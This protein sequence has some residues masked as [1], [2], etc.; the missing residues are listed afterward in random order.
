M[1]KID[2]IISELTP[3]EEAVKKYKWT[4]LDKDKIKK[5][6]PL[7]IIDG[8][9][10]LQK[11]LFLKHNLK[12]SLEENFENHQK[13]EEFLKSA[14]WVIQDWGKI[15]LKRIKNNND[16]TNDNIVNNFSKKIYKG[17]LDLDDREA[18]IIS[19]L[20]KVASFLKP[21]RCAIYDSRAVLSL[22]WLLFKYNKFFCKKELYFPQPKGAG[23]ASDLDLKFIIRMAEES[24]LSLSD[25]NKSLK[26]EIQYEERE[27]YLMYCNLMKDLSDVLYKKLN[28][29]EHGFK[30]YPYIAEMFLFVFSDRDLK[31]LDQDI[32]KSIYLKFK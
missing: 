4:D 32:L 1:N 26:N 14:F 28:L 16:Q 17:D 27:K 5:N 12:K 10:P 30:N 22:N 23:I 7:K 19:S 18:N 29:N 8:Q 2:F 21:D 24:P 11:N 25:F 13:N 15:A 3:I 31:Y 6:C 9:D 20:S